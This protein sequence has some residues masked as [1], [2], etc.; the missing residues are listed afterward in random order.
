[1]PYNLT[2]ALTRGRLVFRHQLL[3]G[4]SWNLLSIFFLQ[5][6]MFVTGIIVARMI[7][8]EAFGVYALMLM[9]LMTLTGVA[10]G[11]SG[12]VATKF[13]AEGLADKPHRVA[14]VLR[15][16]AVATAI[17]GICCAIMLWAGAPFIADEV[18]QKSRVE[19]YLRLVSIAVLFQVFIVYQHGALQGFGAFKRLA[20]VSGIAGFLHCGASVIGAAV[21][22][23]EG[24][25]QGLVVAAIGRAIV[26][27]FILRQTLAEHGIQ[28]S[29]SMNKEEWRQIWTF[30][31]PST[32]AGY[33]TLPCL[34]AVTI[35]IARQTDGLAWSALFLVSHQ[36]KQAVLQLP[37]LLNVVSFSALSR[38]KGQSDKVGF[39]EIFISGFVISFV[40]IALIAAI[41]AVIAPEILSLFGHNFIEGV[42][43]LRIL[44][45]AA[46]LETV[47]SFTYQLVQS[48]G[49]MWHSFFIILVPRDVGYLV[50]TVAGVTIWG[51]N[52][53]GVA[54]LASHA[55]GLLL[56]LLVLR[57]T[58]I[59][60][61]LNS[62]FK[63][64][65]T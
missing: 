32:L 63:L 30:A 37:A 19:P 41:T 39:R 16:C 2:H 23:L 28:R 22:G 14:G 29:S 10:Q 9:T 45:L 34:W 43:L 40:F 8:M 13:V 6:S 50:F 56:T 60:A 3:K 25:V 47:A 24:A 54:Y 52:G 55:A 26:T 57:L 35:F 15:I 65:S 36:I 12:I 5:G 33:V 64:K 11:S 46:V 51:L 21:N 18:L 7:G 4:L 20:I 48:R 44:L 42:T 49:S 62:S 38:A 61:I 31:L 1:M 59:P 27:A 17:G 58:R 53:T